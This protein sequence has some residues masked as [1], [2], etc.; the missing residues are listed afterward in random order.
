MIDTIEELEN[1]IP[2]LNFLKQY[3]ITTYMLRTK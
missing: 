1:L 3:C 2:M